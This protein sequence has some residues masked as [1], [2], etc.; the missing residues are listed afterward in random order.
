MAMSETVQFPK[1]DRPRL[2]GTAASAIGVFLLMLLTAQRDFIGAAY[3]KLFPDQDSLAVAVAPIESTVSSATDERRLLVLVRYSAPATSLIELVD[4]SQPVES[5]EGRVLLEGLFVPR[6]PNSV[7]VPA[8]IAAMTVSPNSTFGM[9]VGPSS[10]GTS[11]S[12]L[13]VVSASGPR[14]L[15]RASNLSMLSANEVRSM[16]TTYILMIIA[17][18]AIAATLPRFKIDL[19]DANT[20]G[21]V[22]PELELERQV[23]AEPAARSVRSNFF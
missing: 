20:G 6:A 10:D 18:I 8:S 23:D 14:S 13:F 19:T 16:R 9:V 3:A 12:H 22:F 17:G 11:E 21:P 2:L 5:L 7:G 1:M 4:S 15:S